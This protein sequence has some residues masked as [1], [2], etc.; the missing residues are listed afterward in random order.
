MEKAR[1]ES[2][3]A[4]K[5]VEHTAALLQEAHAGTRDLETKH[6]ALHG[7]LDALQAE[8]QSIKANALSNHEMLLQEIQNAHKE[9]EDFFEQWKSLEASSQ[10]HYLTVQKI[11]RGGEKHHP[12]HSHLDYVLEGASLFDRQW[13]RL[14]VRLVE[15]HGRAGLALFKPYSHG[16]APLYHWKPDGHENGA[17]FA[18][19]V[20]ADRQSRPKLTGAPSSDLLLVR[21]A[22][23]KILGHLS[24]HG[25]P[26]AGRWLP[27]ARRLLQEIEEIPERLHYDSVAGFSGDKA[28]PSSIRFNAAN[29]YYR[30]NCSRS[31]VLDWVPASSG[32]RLRI[33]QESHETPPMLVH[34]GVET[35]VG[36]ESPAEVEALEK[37][38]P[39]LTHRD[40]TFLLLLAKA[41]PDFVFH[42]CEQH[43]DQK[44]HKDRLTKQAR[45]LYRRLCNLDRRHRL[46][47]A[48]AKLIRNRA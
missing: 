11:L 24:V 1:A 22:A 32:G 43:P 40:R 46:K 9:S 45:Q 42:L 26:E 16:P 25:G 5:E 23:A 4:K 35:V 39:Q 21:D 30:G 44:P 28:D 2:E 3:S 6:H 10:A 34:R 18:L 47:G 38:W 48:I 15:H 8:L 19:F 41:L 12:P 7:D 14:P 29:L 36:F 31:F 37:L 20:P 33:P 27:V 13:H 17:D